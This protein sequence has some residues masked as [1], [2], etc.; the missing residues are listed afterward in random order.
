MYLPGRLQNSQPNGGRILLIFV[1]DPRTVRSCRFQAPVGDVSVDQVNTARRVVAMRTSAGNSHHIGV[2][3]VA[4][5]SDV[6]DGVPSSPDAMSPKTLR[7]SLKRGYEVC[8]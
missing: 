3:A 7:R 1:A 6:L 2:V 5:D 8:R 4:A